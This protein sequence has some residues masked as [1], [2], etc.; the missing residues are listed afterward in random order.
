M[1]NVAVLSESVNFPDNWANKT[2]E[3]NVAMCE[4]ALPLQ[5]ITN[6]TK[7]GEKKDYG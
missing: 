6:T 2:Q 3:Y 7:S 1:F 4:P 5:D